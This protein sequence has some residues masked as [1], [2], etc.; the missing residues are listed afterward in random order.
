MSAS[1]QQ[2]EQFQVVDVTSAR[3][4]MSPTQE[5]FGTLEKTQEPIEVVMEMQPEQQPMEVE[6]LESAR[7]E[8]APAE[9]INV[10]K[11]NAAYITQK[12]EEAQINEN[13]TIE[14]FND[15]LPPETQEKPKQ[16]IK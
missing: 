7:C 5:K 12:T 3:K 1:Q 11:Q 2:Q 16:E 14:D 6:I 8:F 13:V 10:L 15:V 4:M 9:T